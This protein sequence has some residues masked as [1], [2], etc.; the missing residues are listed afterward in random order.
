MEYIHPSQTKFDNFQPQTIL[1]QVD[2]QCNLPCEYFVN[3]DIL[4]TKHLSILLYI[5]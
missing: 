2:Q 1:L 3:M 4:M 5:S